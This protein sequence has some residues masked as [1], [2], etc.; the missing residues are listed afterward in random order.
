MAPC[1]SLRLLFRQG[2]SQGAAVERVKTRLSP[3]HRDQRTCIR[4]GISIEAIPGL[5][6]KIIDQ[7]FWCSVAATEAS[8]RYATTEASQTDENLCT[9]MRGAICPVVCGIG[10]SD[11]GRM[12]SGEAFNVVTSRARACTVVSYI[13]IR[14]QKNSVGSLRGLAARLTCEALGN[15]Q[16][17][18]RLPPGPL[19]GAPCLHEIQPPVGALQHKT[20]GC[21]LRRYSQTPDMAKAAFL[22]VQASR[23]SNLSQ[24]SLQGD[25]ETAHRHILSAAQNNTRQPQIEWPLT[26]ER[27]V[28]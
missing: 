27:S 4:P 10:T 19:P 8:S 24:A 2:V 25:L 15:V 16:Q 6:L 21:Q 20:A 5:R 17:L 13:V 9:G 12:F 18:F 11:R 1:T 7:S 3:P 28:V 26:A 14:N 23:L 22:K